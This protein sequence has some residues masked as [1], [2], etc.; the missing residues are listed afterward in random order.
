MYISY[1]ETLCTISLSRALSEDIVRTGFSP[2]DIYAAEIAYRQ[3]LG[4]QPP[5][6]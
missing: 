1:S 2:I 4:Y 3:Q 6:H 5:V